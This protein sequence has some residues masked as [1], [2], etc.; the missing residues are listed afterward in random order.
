MKVNISIEVKDEVELYNLTTHIKG[1]I[2][3]NNNVNNYKIEIEDC[4][5]ENK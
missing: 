1:I 4:E 3:E 2:Q 5:K